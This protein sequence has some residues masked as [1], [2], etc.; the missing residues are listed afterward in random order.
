VTKQTPI[1]LKSLLGSVIGA[2]VG[3]LLSVA[4]FIIWFAWIWFHPPTS[5]NDSGAMAFGGLLLFFAIMAVVIGAIIGFVI[6]LA[7]TLCYLHRFKLGVAV[8]LAGGSL[9][10]WAYESN[11]VA[12]WLCILSIVSLIW[13]FIPSKSASMA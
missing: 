11:A 4:G 6:G 9:A 3:V 12:I 2:A 1:W 7:V 13:H 10:F 5:K 8:L